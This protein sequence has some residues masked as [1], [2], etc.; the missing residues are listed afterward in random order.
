MRTFT[1]LV[2]A[3]VL[4]FFSWAVARNNAPLAPKLLVGVPLGL[5]LS[6]YAL[7]LWFSDPEDAVDDGEDPPFWLP[8]SLGLRAAIPNLAHPAAK[9][10]VAFWTVLLLIWIGAIDEVV[11]HD[12]SR[13]AGNL[14]R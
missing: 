13:I 4:A 11:R 3:T 5:M 7:L 14:V 1:I 10:V 9:Y 8:R 6:I 12:F 2:L